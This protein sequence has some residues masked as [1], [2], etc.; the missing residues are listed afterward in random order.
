MVG[1]LVHR[2]QTGQL[3]GRLILH[4]LWVLREVWSPRRLSY[5]PS[6]HAEGDSGGKLF[7]LY[8]RGRAVC[9]TPAHL[10]PAG[11]LTIFFVRV[12]VRCGLCVHLCQRL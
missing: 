10:P 4:L 1:L 2:I 7:L 5:H 8:V 11:M 9:H 6:C 12:H 3:T